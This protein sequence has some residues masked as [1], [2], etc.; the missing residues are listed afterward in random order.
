M[1]AGGSS[2]PSTESEAVADGSILYVVGA[3]LSTAISEPDY[4]TRPSHCCSALASAIALQMKPGTGPEVTGG[5]GAPVISEK[6]A[7]SEADSAAV[8]VA[9]V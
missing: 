4:V 9:G 6:V 8:T 2:T 3:A 5:V 7:S 1:Q